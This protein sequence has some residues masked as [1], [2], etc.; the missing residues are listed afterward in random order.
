LPIN[1]RL[2][3][4]KSVVHEK[5]PHIQLFQK[6]NEKSQ[7]NQDKRTKNCFECVHDSKKATY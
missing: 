1:D 7:V 2:N 4:K 5:S 3:S 6:K